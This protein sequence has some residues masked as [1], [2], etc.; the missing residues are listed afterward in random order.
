MKPTLL[1]LAAGIG[2]RYGSLKQL[3]PI[4][5]SGET[6]IDYSVFDAVKAGFGK[7][8]FVIRESIEKEFKEYFINRLP[9]SIEVEYV[10]QEIDK[11]PEGFSVPEGRVKPWGTAHAVL[12]AAEVIKEP[13]VVINADDFY[14]SESFNIVADFLSSSKNNSKTEFCMAGYLLKNTLSDF[15]SVSRGICLA[16]D[17]GNLESVTE[18]TNIEK[19][20]KGIGYY[21]TDKN[22]NSFTGEEFVSMNFW[23]FTPEIFQYIHEYFVEFIKKNYDNIKA[24]FYIPLIVTKLIESGTVKTKVLRSDAKWFGVTY[25]E[26]KEN[27]VNKTLELIKKGDYPK[28]L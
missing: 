18:I 12:M 11:I 19:S 23:G 24:E 8:V 10:L 20:D 9:K 6:I 7:V 15:G 4:G 28:N 25:K 5:P 21:D 2:S 13:F 17:A 3:D 27:A 16:D 26:D 1:I 14:G 22:W